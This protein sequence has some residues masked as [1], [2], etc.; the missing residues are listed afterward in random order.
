MRRRTPARLAAT[1]LALTFAVAAGAGCGGDDTPQPPAAGPS[2][3]GA[4]FPVT[5]GS[6]TLEKRPERI[7]SLSPTTTEMLFAIGAGPQVT[8]ADDNSNYP[9]EAP[10]TEL[11]GFQPNAEAIAAKNPDLVV[12]SNDLNKIVDQLTKLKIPVYLAPAAVTLDDTYKE[13]AE[14]GKLTGRQPEA[15]ALVQ[16]MKDDIGKLVQQVPSRMAKLTYYY[17]LGP[18]LYSVT[19]KTFIGSLFTTLGLENIA[20]PADPGGAKGGYPQ[21]SAEAIIKA[22]PDMIFLADTK[23]CKQSQASVKARKGWAGVD[24]VRSGYVVE[25]DDDIASRWGPRVVDLM[26]TVVDA[27]AKVPA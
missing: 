13:I 19:S 8:A 6:L 27:V 25:L 10:M 17:E 26:R 22:N 11:S 23:C 9:R 3:A 21:L 12:L 18:E 16:R 1:L 4:A 5:V 2:S 7:V 24:A 15:D 14:I 20:D